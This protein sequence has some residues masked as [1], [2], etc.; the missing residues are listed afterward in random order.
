[1]S[2]TRFD[3]EFAGELTPGTDPKK[4][5]ARV[6][7][8]FKL[9]DDAVAQ[10]FSGS[11]VTI[12]RG[13][14]GALAARLHAAFAQAGALVRIVPAGGD[15]LDTQSELAPGAV[16]DG[17]ASL[18]ALELFGV[19]RPKPKHP[20]LHALF[21]YFERSLAFVLLLLIA[22]VSVIA[23]IE[24][25]FILYQDLISTDGF[26]LGLNELFEVFGMFLIVLIAVELMASIYMYMVDKSVHVEMMLLIAITALSR[27]VVVLDLE[28]KGD[29]AMYMIGMAA[30]LATLIGGYYLVKH[31][32][33]SVYRHRP[34]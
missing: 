14:D 26:L 9:T 17:A 5:R 28:G 12:K 32:D 27:K 16:D 7:A 34:D 4:A 21:H 19:A 29:P 1:M 30:L 11:A 3:L 15:G 2:G 25:C 20:I 6:K 13:I 22:L 8:L 23:L 31:L 10:L 33:K 18:P 24:L